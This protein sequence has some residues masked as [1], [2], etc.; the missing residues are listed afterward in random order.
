MSVIGFVD[1]P[2]IMLAIGFFSILCLI[3]FWI[4]VQRPNVLLKVLLSMMLE[5]GFL[6]TICNFERIAE[7]T[8]L[9]NL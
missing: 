3:F 4:R 7:D 9:T 1:S 5:T 6:G 8:P 2:R